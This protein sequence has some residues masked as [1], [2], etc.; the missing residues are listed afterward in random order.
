VVLGEFGCG[1]FLHNLRVFSGGFGVFF[2]VGWFFV[3]KKGFLFFSFGFFLFF[4]VWCWGFFFF[5]LGFSQ[6]LFLRLFSLPGSLK[7]S[8]PPP[9]FPRQEFFS[10]SP[11]LDVGYSFLPQDIIFPRGLY[12]L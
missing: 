7:P 11:Q 4:F 10:P 12:C 1:Q 8:F 9:F 2:F 3:S 5:L 6:Q